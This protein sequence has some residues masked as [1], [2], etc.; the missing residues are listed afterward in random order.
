MKCPRC[1]SENAVKNGFAVSRQRY[2]CKRC[3]CQFTRSDPRGKSAKD[4]Q[5]AAFLHASGVPMT[6]V[7]K[8]VGVS[9]QTVSRWIHSICGDADSTIP[10]AEPFKKITSVD[11]LEYLSRLSRKELNREYLMLQ[12]V[13]PSGGEIRIFIC[14]PV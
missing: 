8:L 5:L 14:N 1:N 3:G 9:V 2:K 7:A 10:K 6:T 11:V 4:K 12:T 13:L